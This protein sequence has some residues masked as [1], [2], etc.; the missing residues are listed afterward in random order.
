MP[1]KPTFVAE[2]HRCPE[3]QCRLKHPADYDYFD[4]GLF[5]PDSVILI[6]PVCKRQFESTDKVVSVGHYEYKDEPSQDQENNML[7]FGKFCEGFPS[8]QCKYLRGYSGMLS[9][10]LKYKVRVSPRKGAYIVRCKQCRK[11]FGEE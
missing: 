4:G 7:Q 6:C 1:R 3:C 10:C 2:Y 8:L 9:R 11:E 5:I